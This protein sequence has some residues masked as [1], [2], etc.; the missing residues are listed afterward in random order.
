[1][2]LTRF[3]ASAAIVGGLTAGAIAA[4]T[5]TAGAAPLPQ[6]PL[7]AEPTPGTPPAWAPPKP[8]EPLW[9]NGQPVV[10]DQGW[11]HWGVWLNGAF[12]PTF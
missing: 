6:V 4:G 3:I 2:K 1:M 8:V 9:G 11:Q 12:V 10:W 5:T 7:P